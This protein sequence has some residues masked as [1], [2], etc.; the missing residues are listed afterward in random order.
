LEELDVSGEE[1]VKKVRDGQITLPYRWFIGSAGVR[2]FQGLREKKILGTRCHRCGRVLVPGRKF[3]PRDFIELFDWVELPDE[4]TIKTF[5]FVNYSFVGQPRDPPYIV[6]I[7]DL[8]GADTGFSHYV[9]G[10]DFSDPEKVKDQVKIG[11]RVKAVWRD[12][13]VGAITDID[14]FKPI[15]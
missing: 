1:E 10:I 4:G 13:R 11:M 12:K 3:C 5:A 15:A 7:I 6:A 9:M 8:D 14:Y 2:F